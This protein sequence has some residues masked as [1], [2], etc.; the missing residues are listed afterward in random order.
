MTV[1]LIAMQRASPELSFVAGVM[2]A[3]KDPDAAR[4]LVNYLASPPVQSMLKKRAWSRQPQ[5][6]SGAQAS[7]QGD[8][9]SRRLL[10]QNRRF[11]EMP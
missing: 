6:D 2:T 11:S 9:P 7:T 1:H 10:Q 8:H 5:N 4:S 3:A